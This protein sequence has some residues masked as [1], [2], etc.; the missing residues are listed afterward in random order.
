MQLKY[1]T[2]FLKITLIKYKGVTATNYAT[3]HDLVLEDTSVYINGHHQ[4]IFI[5]KYTFE[6]RAK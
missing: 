3:K 5:T 4:H 6:F 2:L 1:E